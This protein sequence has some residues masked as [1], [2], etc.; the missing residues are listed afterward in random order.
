MHGHETD[1]GAVGLAVAFLLG[2]LVA[3]LCWTLVLGIGPPTA[4]FALF[5]PTA[6]T[7]DADGD[8]L[9]DDWE[10]AGETP[11]G[12]PL[13]DADPNR[14]DVYVHIAYGANVD[15]LSATELARLE[16]LWADMPVENPDGTTGI[17]LHVVT[18]QALGE[19]VAYENVSAGDV[20]GQYTETRLGDGFCTYYGVTLG[21]IDDGDHLGFADA[22]GYA[23]LVHRNT[24][25][26]AH[27]GNGVAGV[28]T[29]ELL[30]SVAGQVGEGGHTERGWLSGSATGPRDFLSATTTDR[31]NERG[32]TFPETTHRHYAETCSV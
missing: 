20:R 23:S 19:P 16:R 13:P 1:R 10:R 32:F 6:P 30:H 11:S 4:D 26:Y 8:L 18:Q 5:G 28:V 24:P 12:A 21:S 17:D 3:L 9:A 22:P 14:K 25:W 15:P 31:L 7:P 27:D 2:V 29:H